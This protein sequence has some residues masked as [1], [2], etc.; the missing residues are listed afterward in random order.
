M[1]R[2]A[3][4]G[5]IGLGWQLGLRNLS[6]GGAG[7]WASPGFLEARQRAAA[8]QLKAR[9]P[10][11]KVLVSA[12]LDATFPQWNAV[13]AVLRNR[14][15][16]RRIFVTRPNG[17][18]WLDNRWG[19]LFE[20]PWYNFSSVEAVD[21]WIERGPIAEAMQASEL[22][23]CYLDGAGPDPPFYASFA[24]AQELRAFRAAQARAL[25]RAVATWRRRQPSKWL[26]GYAAP[27][28]HSAQNP[29]HCPAG[30]CAGP[31]QLKLAGPAACAAT[32]R[33]VRRRSFE[34]RT[35]R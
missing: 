20:Q 13:S 21:W 2:E 35:T 5:I 3:S 30:S 22:D 32:M 7:A 17:S 34:I 12:E 18:L 6:G 9:H 31:E 10:G 8:R 29:N 11:V 28:V 33:C 14:T 1:A 27:R 24:S 4:L 26:A 15:L 16:A 23:G 19:G 25:A